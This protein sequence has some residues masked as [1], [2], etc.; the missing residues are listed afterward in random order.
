MVA[1]SLWQTSCSEK[2]ITGVQGY[3]G[4]QDLKKGNYRG[5]SSTFWTVFFQGM[6]QFL[7]CALE[8]RGQETSKS[9]A[10]GLKP[11]CRVFCHC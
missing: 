3:Q 8:V 1:W 4:S 2:I 5:V 7:R 6:Y 11:V 10:N 9:T